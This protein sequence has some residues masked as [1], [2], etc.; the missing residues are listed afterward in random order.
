MVPSEYE[1]ELR[2][3]RREAHDYGDSRSLPLDMAVAGCLVY[4][5]RVEGAK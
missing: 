2:A 4:I 1:V 5:A 3:R